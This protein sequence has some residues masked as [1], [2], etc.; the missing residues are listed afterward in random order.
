MTE[1]GCHYSPLSPALSPNS[2]GKGAATLFLVPGQTP[3][4]L[5]ACCLCVT[6]R[7]DIY[8]CQPILGAREQRLCAWCPVPPAKRLGASC[9]NVS[10]PFG[11]LPQSAER[12]G[13]SQTGAL[14]VPWISE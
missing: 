13:E 10:L 8:T 4:C 6:P 12:M 3:K 2:G 9:L 5:A 14:R 11:C 1:A 7:S